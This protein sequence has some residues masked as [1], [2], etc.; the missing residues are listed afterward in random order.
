[1][2]GSQAYAFKAT[3]ETSTDLIRIPLSRQPQ[4]AE[5]VAQIRQKLLLQVLFPEF[6]YPST[7]M[8]EMSSLSC[9]PKAATLAAYIATAC[10]QYPVWCMHRG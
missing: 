9:L 4:P 3:E 1:M 8:Y 7:V 6:H 2:I 10:L 5:E